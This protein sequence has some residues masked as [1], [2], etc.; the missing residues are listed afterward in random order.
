MCALHASCLKVA[1]ARARHWATACTLLIDGATGEIADT[2]NGGW[3]VVERPEGEPPIYRRADG[4][5]WWLFV[6]CD[7]T[8]MVSSKDAKDNRKTHSRGWAHSVAAAEGRL[9]HEIGTA[10]KVWNG[11]EWTEQT[12]R[13]VHGEEAEAAITEVVHACMCAH[14]CVCACMCVCLTE[15]MH[16][17]MPA[18]VRVCMSARTYVIAQA[19]HVRIWSCI[20]I[21]IICMR[22]CM[23]LCTDVTVHVFFYS[24]AHM[25]VYSCAQAAR[26]TY[27]ALLHV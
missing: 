11:R 12:V 23:Y 5:D 13:V 24:H 22:A 15:S 6:A 2:V 18:C 4:S 26:C 3:E 16:A 19:I 17:C 14:V 25:D 20:C 21:C 27:T 1:A 10:W 9:P 7:G 8:W